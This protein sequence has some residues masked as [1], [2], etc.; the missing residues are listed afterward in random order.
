MRDLGLVPNDTTYSALT[1]AVRALD[2]FQEM[3]D[4]GMVLNGIT[5]NAEISAWGER[6]RRAVTSVRQC[7]AQL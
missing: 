6:T 4:Q 3:R 5:Y 1:N 7:C 2:L